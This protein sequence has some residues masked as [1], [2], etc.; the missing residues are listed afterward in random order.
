MFRTGPLY[1]PGYANPKMLRML[2]DPKW[3]SNSLG[4][5]NSVFSRVA[6]ARRA[7][8]DNAR[9]SGGALIKARQPWLPGNV[10]R[11]RT[12]LSA[13]GFVGSVADAKFFDTAEASYP[14]NT[15][16]SITH[17]NIVPQ[18]TTIN[19]RVGKAY[20]CTSVAVRG[21]VQCDTTTTLATAA[22]YLV[23]DYQPNKVLAAI[24]DV[25]DS[26]SSSSFP[27]RENA[28]RFK[29]IKKWSY[30]LSG[31]STTP[32]AAFQS[33]RI[34]DYV[35]LPSDCSTL[36][37]SADSTG[38]I[39]DM[40]NGALLFIS[41]GNIAAGTADGNAVLGFRLNFTD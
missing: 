29:I 11:G 20:K 14:T 39:G 3:A 32:S 38:V 22:C 18:G 41:V 9:Y 33:Y 15:T 25:L 37:T 4:K 16:G 1:A 21:Q 40:I 8:L 10:R 34:D 35:K 7:G 31:N 27:K 12:N 6:A 5:Y 2:R 19:S 28:L 30:C 36:L 17:L 13:R 23:W 26:V 24:T